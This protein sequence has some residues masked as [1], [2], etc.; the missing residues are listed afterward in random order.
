MLDE[1]LGGGV[2]LQKNLDALPPPS[3]AR[4]IE[5]RRTMERDVLLNP[6]LAALEHG[7]E[8][9]RSAVLRAFDGSFFKGRTYARQPSNMIDVG[10]DREF[11]FLYEPPLDQLE[12]TFASLLTAS[13]P[14]DAR[15][16]A[17][18]LCSFLKVP[19]RTRHAEI[20]NRL[21]EAFWDPDAGVREAARTVVERELNLDG[22]ESD[23]R[24]MKEIRFVLGQPQTGHKTMALVSA[25][26]RSGRL[27]EQP[28]I[29]AAVRRLLPLPDAAALLLPILGGPEFA[30]EER[31]EVLDR[32]WDR[33]TLDQR[34]QALDLLLT[35]LELLDRA[36]PPAK[37][38][39]LV[40]RAAT[41]RAPTVR[42]HAW[43]GLQRLPEFWSGR[44][45]PA[46]L[47][48]A[49]AD[50]A[51]TMRRL[52]L[53]LAATKASFW[54]RPDALEYLA[55]LLVDPDAAIR[56]DALDLVKH[57][58]LVAKH[59]PLAR[60][61]KA[62]SG[63]LALAERAA[64]VLLASGLDPPKVIADVSLASTGQPDLESFR[65]TVN[66]LF[67]QSGDDGH[68][69]AD[70]HAN[71]TILRIAE[72]DPGKEFS[73]DQIMGNYISALKVVNLGQP[74]SSLLLR[75]PRSPQGQGGAESSS[76][77]GLTHVGGTRWEGPEHPAYLAILD[78]IRTAIER[79]PAE[80]AR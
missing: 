6:V 73:N 19:E 7:N 16:Q 62:L 10:N 79:R 42:E 61:V 38:V 35:R 32:G 20:R 55:R 77:T 64:A 75:K 46:L 78:W 36:T 44:S 58:R 14:A 45:A 41:D 50:D 25:I 47:L 71:H 13:L 31:F 2:S 37:A 27:R 53:A 67:Y 66:P 34:L 49:L 22:I 69:C 63:D 51:S 18:Q 24:L 48:I 9:Q 68:A 11:G 8:L 5:A 1:N 33:L 28:E 70:C 72:A 39:A 40:R 74:E 43:T 4:V 12:R 80:P 59:P 21:I 76:P 54:T 17:I 26:S 23:A 30:D 3:R 60:R 65:R 57:H 29:R 52:G 15:R 56:S